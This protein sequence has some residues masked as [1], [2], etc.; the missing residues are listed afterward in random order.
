[1]NIDE[2]AVVPL[3]TYP[4]KDV[5]DN[6]LNGELTV[7]WRNWD[8]IIKT[9]EMVYVNSVNPGEIKGPHIHKNRTSYFLCLQGKMII[10][11]RDKNEK[12][13]E[14]ETN[15]TES[16]L[17]SVSNGTPAAII[18]PSKNI[19]KILVLA[20]VAWKPNDNEMENTT[21][22]DYDWNKWKKEDII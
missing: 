18:N 10:V 16:K 15:S 3:D 14:I 22:D 1:M 17:I 6:R 19:S 7:I 9:P 20:D 4:T 13:H 5:K 2:I 12:Y 8:K 11:I 21:F